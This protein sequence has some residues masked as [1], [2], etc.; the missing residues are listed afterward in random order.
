MS[1]SSQTSLQAESEARLRFEMVLAD[2][3]S[4][5][6]NVAASDV[7][8][9]IENAQ[10]VICESL[11]IDHSS[12]WQVAEEN[13]DL[14]VMTHVYR[15]PNLKP[16]PI[17]PSVKEYFPWSSSKILNN[18]TV[19]V[20]NTATLPPEAA[21]DRKSWEEY[22]IHSSLIIPLTVGGGP[23]V[24]VL[25]F[26]SKEERDWLEPLQRRLQILAHVFAQALDRKHAERKL[27]ESEGRQKRHEEKL[28][29]Y[30]RAIENAEEMIAVVDR[31]YRYLIA[32][33]QFLKLRNKTREQ[34]VGRFAHE[35]LQEGVFEAEVKPRLD[36]CFK[37]KIVRYEMKY[38][39]PELGERDVLV[40]YFP[41]EGAIGIDR[42]VCILQDITERKRAEQEFSKANERLRLA[43]EAGSA[44]GWD[45]DLRTGKN[46]WFGKAHAQLG[47]THDE[48]LGSVAEFWARVHED[49]RARLEH[50]LQISNEK[51]DEFAEDFRVVWR[52]GT[53]HWLRSRG[54]H[55]YSGNGEPERMLG[56]CI[57]I[58]ESKRAEEALKESETRFRLVADTAP[59]MI[60]MSGLDKKPSY[61][62]QLWL[63]FTGFSETDLQ[64]RFAEIVHPDD[65]QQCNEVYCQ[66]F[67]QRQPFRKECR[68]R[69]H[70]GQY[71]WMLDIGVP[72]FHKDGSFA[73][74]IGSCIDVTD[75]KLAEDALTNMSRKLVEA[76]EQE[77]ARIGREL[78]DDINQRLAML[79]LGLEQ[80]QANPS[81]VQSH[82][83]ELRKQTTELSND[84]QALSHDL[85]SSQ[86]EYLGVVAGMKSWCKEFGER[87]GMQIDCRHDVRSTLPQEIGLCLFRVL[88]EALHN[89]AKHSGVKRIEVQLHEEASEI[90]LIVRDLGKGFDIE[91]AR[92]GRGL[93]LTSMR[94]RVRLVNGTITIDSK[95]MGGTTIHVRVPLEADQAQRAAG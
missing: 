60:W 48:T 85:H 31:E 84:V 2:V 41:I 24:G 72:R 57:D 70:D 29:E 46:V 61:F 62:S 83:Q 44:G 71:R 37:G 36:E 59:V 86:L 78:H 54:R 8:S 18:E 81:E 1:V 82:L 38:T 51:H 5:F 3:C 75:R 53:T 12:V 33:R 92:Q 91:A 64:N 21:T 80:L 45:F 93:G 17:H 27:R 67:D 22:G 89:A 55:Y 73:G 49:D 35:V 28:R 66:G 23:L 77:R 95:P 94:E 20:P 87:Q 4:Q 88:Q 39:Y 65:Y 68:L 10:R 34:V 40:S 56:I 76:Q 58:T 13:S 42:A 11:G 9:K 90:H 15:D 32:N 74:Y 16:L 30:E 19:C 52:D 47:M 26:D 69:R 7:D 43:L 63:D 6:V 14:P 79:A 50:A 25:A